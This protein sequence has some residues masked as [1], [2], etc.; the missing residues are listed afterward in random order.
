MA[1]VWPLYCWT[2]PAT[3]S[4]YGEGRPPDRGHSACMFRLTLT[5]TLLDF[6]HGRCRRRYNSSYQDRRCTA[7][8]R[9]RCYPV[10]QGHHHSSSTAR[11]TGSGRKRTPRPTGIFSTASRFSLPVSH[12]GRPAAVCSRLPAARCSAAGSPRMASSIAHSSQ[13]RFSTSS[14]V[15]V[16][17][18]MTSWIFLRACAQQAASVNGPPS[19]S[20]LNNRS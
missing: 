10:L 18:L 13:I 14:A 20:A 17:V 16:W 2:T 6:L 12:A 7:P 9:R 19:R 5:S 11:P 15:G 1:T 4:G 8:V 3:H